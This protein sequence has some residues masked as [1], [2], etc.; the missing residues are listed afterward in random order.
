MKKGVITMCNNERFVDRLANAMNKAKLF[1]TDGYYP[2]IEDS[3]GKEVG[4]FVC[5]YGNGAIVRFLS[6]IT[7]IHGKDT[8]TVNIDY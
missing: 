3:T 2:I 7:D 6:W 4:R 1:K 8:R 5:I